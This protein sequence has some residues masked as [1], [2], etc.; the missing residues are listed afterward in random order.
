MQGD[1]RCS[2]TFTKHSHLF[3]ITSKT[4]NIASNPPQCLNLWREIKLQEVKLIACDKNCLGVEGH[5]WILRLLILPRAKDKKKIKIMTFCVNLIWD[6]YPYQV[7]LVLG[8]G[9]G[10]HGGVAVLG[11]FW[12]EE[13]IIYACSHSLQG[14]GKNCVNYIVNKVAIK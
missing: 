14:W 12:H 9:R 6:L 10:E 5:L 8:K 2:C 11:Y 3:G 4:G 1:T 7:N 13:S